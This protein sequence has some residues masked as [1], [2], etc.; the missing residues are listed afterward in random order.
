MAMGLF[1]GKW[2]DFPNVKCIC[3]WIML[4]NVAV[5]TVLFVIALH[6]SQLSG[7]I[8]HMDILYSLAYKENFSS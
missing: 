1:S 2:H 3:T 5:N 7:C 6:T 8:Y 4:S